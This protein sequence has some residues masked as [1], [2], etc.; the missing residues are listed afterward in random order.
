DRNRSHWSTSKTPSY[1]KSVSWQH[2]RII[3]YVI[4]NYK[5]KFITPGVIDFICTSLIAVILTIKLFLLINQFEKQQIKKGRDITSA[6]IMSR[7]IKITIIV[8]LVLLYGE[9]FGMS[10]SG[11][12]TFG[13]IGGLAVGMAGKDILSN[14][15]SGIMLYFDRPFSIGDWIRSP[16]RNIEGTVAEIGWRITKITTF[17]NRPL[18][19]PNSLF[20]SISVENPGRMTNRRITTTIGLRYEDAA[21]VGVIVEAVRE[22]LKNHPAIDQRQTLLVYFNQFAD[23]SLN[24]MVYCFTKTTVWAEWLAAQQ[25]VY[26][27]IIDIVQSH[28]ADFAFPSQTLYMDN[29]TPPEQGR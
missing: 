7:I 12:L 18:Y 16:D 21:K 28:G 11:L 3:N 9:H 24:I 2:H 4:E 14:F 6:R 8:V 26:L 5:L 19:V 27:K 22:M 15:F 23:S 29:I 13:G 20:S 1:T 10:L 25:D 17:D